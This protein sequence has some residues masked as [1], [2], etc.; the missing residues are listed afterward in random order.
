MGFFSEKG[1]R[2]RI[3]ADIA[4]QMARYGQDRWHGAYDIFEP[5]PWD[6]ILRGMPPDDQRAWVAALSDVI[7]PL[8]GWAAYGAEETVMKAMAHP[9]DLPAYRAILDA[10][11]EF[12]RSSGIWESQ[13]SPD[14]RIYWSDQ[15]P[16]E[17]WM[18]PA[19]PP[20]RADAVITDLAIGEERRVVVMTKSPTSNEVYVSRRAADTY[21]ASVE[22]GTGSERTRNDTSSAGSL[23]DLYCLFGQVMVMPN[24]WTDP[25]LEPFFPF[26]HPRL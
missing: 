18:V 8:G 4:S 17:P 10:S 12:Q 11:L 1:K 19:A 22:Q 9:I 6:D 23:Y 20:S 14:E 16:G 5:G 24:H 2:I 15:H 25:E 3:P 7:V 21:V 26:P 13:L